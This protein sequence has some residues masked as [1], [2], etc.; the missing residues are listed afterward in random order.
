MDPIFEYGRTVGQ[1]TTGGYV[2]R[3]SV[4]PST[5]RGRYF[6]GD[7]SSGRI[8]SL[9]LTIDPA[10]GNATASNLIDHTTELASSAVVSFGVDSTGELYFINYGAGRISRIAS[11]GPTMSVDKPAL[12]FGAVTTGAAFSSQTGT[13]AIRLTQTGTAP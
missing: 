5:Y 4:L 3:G 8:W 1:A 6:F 12:A 2:Y 11:A 7:S 10:T 13:Q 9:A